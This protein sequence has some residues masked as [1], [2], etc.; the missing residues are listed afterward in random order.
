MTTHNSPSIERRLERYLIGVIE[1]REASRKEKADAAK[2]L[3]QL[4][5]L[6]AQRQV[7]RK[8]KQKAASSVLGAMPD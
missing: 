5:V 4:K 3:T 6:R 2:Q 7:E 1:D 8:P